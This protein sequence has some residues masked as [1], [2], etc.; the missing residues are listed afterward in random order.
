ME[1]RSSR[2][3][4]WLVVLGLAVVYFATARGG[5]ALALPPDHKA[6]AIWPPSGI[7]LAAV[8][9]LGFRVSPGIWFGAFL[10]NLWDAFDPTKGGS[11]SAHVASSGAIAV[12]STLQALAGAALIRRLTGPRHLLDHTRD[13]FRFVAVAFAMCLTGATIGVLALCT[14]GLVP[15]PAFATLWWTWWLGD[16]VGVLLVTPVILTWVRPATA[17]HPVGAEVV[18]TFAVLLVIC[19]LVFGGWG[20]AV[21][22]SGLAYLSIPFLVWASVRFG[23]R[24]A[25]LTI[26]TVAVFAVWGTISGNGP[27]VR[28]DVYESLL[29]LDMFLAVAV[30]TSLAPCAILQERED[31]NNALRV[32]ASQFRQL[33][34]SLPQI[35]WTT[36]PDG[37]TAYLNQRWREYTGLTGVSPDE[38]ARVIH[39]DDLSRMTAAWAITH[40]AGTAFQYEFRLRPASGGVYR[41]FLARAVPVI[42]PDGARGGWFGTY[43]DI[44]ELKSTQTELTRQRTELQLILDTVPALIFH[45]DRNHRLVRVNN[46]V[47]RLIGLPRAAIEGRT[48]SELGSPRKDDYRQAEEKIMAEGRGVWDILEPL[49]TSS[50]PRWLQTTKLP[51]RDETG[52]VTGIIG[53]SVDIT[54]RKLAEEEVRRLNVELEHRVAERTAV[55]ETRAAALRDSEERF[56]SA[57]DHAAIGMALIA[58][59]GRWLKVNQSVCELVGYTEAELLA[60]DVQTI[61]HPDDLNADLALVGMVLSGE[62]A[63]YQREARYFH[64]TGDAVHILLAVSLVRDARGQPLYFISQIQ[65]IM[66]RKRAETRLLASVHEKEVMLKEI[67]H[68][69]KN[70]LQIVSTLLD[71]QSDGI[72][73]PAALTAFRESRDRVRSMGL[74]HER[75]YRSE[76][77]ASIEFGSYVR[78]LA[79][80]LFHAYRADAAVRLTVSV[81]LPPV[82]LNLAIPCGLLVNELVSN[83][84]KYAFVGREGGIINVSLEY[85]G[86][87]SYVLSVADDG[88]GLPDGFDFRCATSFGLQLANT[89]AEQLGGELAM[90]RTGGTRFT[91]RFPSRA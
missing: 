42:G 27:F 62:L 86:V 6:T 1:T 81:S 47:I 17:R 41:W 13:V 32:S 64:K 21:R 31:A 20:S 66:E 83:C 23:S 75:L 37:V 89:L 44:E 8:L 77:L 26:V 69:V 48:D 65:N 5:L 90:D 38:L 88:V 91:V 60:T 70:N 16:A 9:L 56:R 46:E 24:R 18:G 11:V 12:G 3:R 85:A 49:H 33:A 55:A 34:E 4:P 40:R 30:V 57:F 15:W 61:T 14:S 54:E 50:G 72:T 74:I 35:V 59:D 7:A 22:A 84:L 71:L 45:K 43:T 39:P 29:L 87:G 51:Y 25:A 68:R 82:P 2:W 52:R 78:Q 19:T 73:D 63:T 28:A 76:N 58:P 80:D 79:E 36:T 10:A 53:F 67:H